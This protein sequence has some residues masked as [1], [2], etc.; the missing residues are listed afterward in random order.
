MVGQFGV[1]P[2]G[3]ATLVV[4]E[5]SAETFSSVDWST[6]LGD[7]LDRPQVPVPKSLM[8]SFLVVVG[9]VLADCTAELSLAHWDQV[10]QAL[11]LDRED[12]SLSV[13]VQVRTACREPEAV[14]ATVVE[15]GSESGGVERVAVDA[16][17]DEELEDGP[18]LEPDDEEDAVAD[19]SARGRDL[20]GEEV[21]RGHQLPVGLQE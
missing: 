17:E 20:D 10:V 11:G 18:G 7:L 16:A 2:L 1:V 15:H 13:R 12:E 19:E 8:G 21:C 14:D 5:K 4:A 3:G 9:H 6:L